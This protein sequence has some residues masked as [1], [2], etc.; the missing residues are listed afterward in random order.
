[1]KNIKIKRKDNEPPFAVETLGWR[2]HHIGI[3]VKDPIPGTTLHLFKT[4]SA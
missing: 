3:P 2:Y 4:S 1:M